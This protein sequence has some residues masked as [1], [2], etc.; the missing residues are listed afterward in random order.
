MVFAI[1]AASIC[2][3]ILSLRQFINLAAL[4]KTSDVSS[5]IPLSKTSSDAQVTPSEIVSVLKT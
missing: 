5:L 4:I 1:F 2:F 3:A